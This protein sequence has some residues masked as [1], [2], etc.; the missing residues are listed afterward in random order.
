MPEVRLHHSGQRG[1][2]SSTD[3]P[4]SRRRRRLASGSEGPVAAARPR[5]LA[6]VPSGVA[7]SDTR[8]SARRDA[9][10]EAG[11]GATGA[12]SAVGDVSRPGRT[13]SVPAPRTASVATKPGEPTPRRCALPRTSWQE[14]DDADEQPTAIVS[15]GALA[16]AFG[17]LVSAPSGKVVDSVMPADEWYVGI[18]DVSVGPI[19]LAELRS[20]AAS[21]KVDAESLV[22]RD[23]LEDWRPLR[24]F[25]EL[26]AV[27]EESL[28]SIRAAGFPLPAPKR[29]SADFGTPLVSG[30]TSVGVVTDDL[31]GRRNCALANAARR[32]VGDRRRAGVRHRHR[33]V[34]PGQAETSRDDREIRRSSG[35]RRRAARRG[36]CGRSRPPVRSSRGQC[37]NEDAH[38]STHVGEARRCRT[39]TDKNGGLSGLKGLD[40]LRPS[41]P[42]PGSTTGTTSPGGGSGTARLRA[43][44]EHG[45]ALHG[46]REAKLLAARARFARSVRAD[47]GARRRQ[48]HRRPVGKCAG[49]VDERRA[50]RLSGSCKLHCGPRSELAIPGD[51]WNDD[52]KRAVRLRRPVGVAGI[53]LQAPT[54]SRS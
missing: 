48:H 9:R 11:D 6:V 18:N 39:E 31:G 7:A 17:A 32:V 53:K 52:R 12:A 30:V 35:A 5:A 26:L 28:S 51:G 38:G 4:P 8:A 47:F 34:L 16:A 20:K 44:P 49:R 3:A 22:W 25:P 2:A 54:T 21:G 1:P 19:R 10:A 29:D 46:Q 33:R 14:F 37:S 23:G 15:G 41:S 36:G 50:A 24:T 43:D 42:G 40:G 27:L 45:R 13:R